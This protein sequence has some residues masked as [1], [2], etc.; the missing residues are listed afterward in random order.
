MDTAFA[1]DF[2]LAEIPQKQIR[3]IWDLRKFRKGK[4]DRFG[5]CGN[6][7]KANSVDLGLAESAQRQMRPI[8]DLRKFRK[9]KFSRFGTC[10]KRAKAQSIDYVLILKDN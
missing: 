10:G 2:I 6:S 8:W 5:A 1:V 9:G 7:A 4:F 3:S